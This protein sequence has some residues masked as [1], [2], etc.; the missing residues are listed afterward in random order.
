[1][2][3]ISSKHLLGKPPAHKGGRNTYLRLSPIVGS[4]PEPGTDSP[5]SRI[6]R[7]RS[8]PPSRV[9][10][11]N[12]SRSNSPTGVSLSKIPKSSSYR[13]ISTKAEGRVASA[14]PKGLPK[15]PRT[16]TNRN[17]AG[18][19]RN[20]SK[21]EEQ[22]SI[23]SN[24]DNEEDWN[25]GRTRSKTSLI[26]TRSRTN[27]NGDSAKKESLSGTEKRS[28]VREK[29][30][31]TQKKNSRIVITSDESRDDE[32]LSVT[33]DATGM[34]PTT[35]LIQNTASVIAAAAHV[36]AKIIKSRE[37]IASMQ[38][39]ISD[40][41]SH[42]KE[43]DASYDSHG[44]RFHQDSVVSMGSH[45]IPGSTTHVPKLNSQGS[46]EKEAPVPT[47]PGSKL[48]KQL[49]SGSAGHRPSMAQFAK[50]SSQSSAKHSLAQVL[51]QGSQ[52]GA[53]P[54]PSTQESVGK[55]SSGQRPSLSQVA[56]QSVSPGS[57]RKSIIAQF[58]QSSRPSTAAKPGTA[59][60]NTSGDGNQSPNPRSSGGKKSIYAVHSATHLA[61]DTFSR[62]SSAAVHNSPGGLS[63]V[64]STSAASTAS[65][66]SVIPNRK[67]SNIRKSVK[68]AGRVSL[69]MRNFS[70]SPAK[71]SQGSAGSRRTSLKR[72]STS[73]GKISAGLSPKSPKA[74]P[75]VPSPDKRKSS[76]MSS[77]NNTPTNSIK[78]VKEAKE[79][80]KLA[81]VSSVKKL[82]DRAK[83]NRTIVVDEIKP[84]QITVKEK[85]EEVEV[86]SGNVSLPTSATNGIGNQRPA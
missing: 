40:F 32:I 13:N 83:Q 12:V 57:A 39:G 47:T 2:T 81:A 45:R 86:Q 37:S 29:S 71:T 84:I 72:I 28:S 67:F 48:A 4:S 73:V 25:G 78:T 19:R 16:I 69:M 70:K 52:G 74:K 61:K 6:P 46:D 51:K 80:N 26:K 14:K 3:N 64:S 36:E 24:L 44:R 18:S 62:P 50:Q 59:G 54:R 53:E 35:E 77:V 15:N 33:I 10:S 9:G 55:P 60:S 68:T 42:R 65:Q 75:K 20:L 85:G 17:R 76:T 7:S 43:S 23:E 63:T 1:M 56:K 21:L 31:Q 38:S 30:T 27:L 58:A 8:Q 11:R 79:P 66:R 49:S 41:G 22:S 5:G 82:S 34:P